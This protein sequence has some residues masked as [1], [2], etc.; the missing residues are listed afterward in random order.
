MKFV[1]S[2]PFRQDFYSTLGQIA[3]AMGTVENHINFILIQMMDGNERLA[4]N[5]TFGS[6]LDRVLEVL[7]ATFYSANH[8]TDAIT[9]FEF[10]LAE[11]NRLN[12]ERNRNFHCMWNIDDNSQTLHR[13]RV[14]KHKQGLLRAPD[15]KTVP[16]EELREL[17]S[18]LWVLIDQLN[19]FATKFYR[20]PDLPALP[21]G[22]QRALDEQYPRLLEQA[23]NFSGK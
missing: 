9:I 4:T 23:K 2:T 22:E 17:N 18:Q 8:E 11:I 5:L 14:A 10:L 21:S 13:F 16:L 3:V 6:H 19:V 12:S 1:P 7:K 20:R 15:W